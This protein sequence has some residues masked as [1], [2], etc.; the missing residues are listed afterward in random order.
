MCSSVFFFQF[1][2][3]IEF[4]WRLARA[5]GDMCELSINTQEKKHYANIG[6]Y[7]EKI[8][9]LQVTVIIYN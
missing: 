1:R 6:K 4:I 2:D 9:H 7:F 3:E 5:Y 8:D